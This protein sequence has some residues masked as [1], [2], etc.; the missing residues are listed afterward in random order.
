MMS[1]TTG[2]HAGS[3]LN[4]FNPSIVFARFD[5]DRGHGHVLE[6]YLMFIPDMM[7]IRANRRFVSHSGT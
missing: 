6:Q 5:Y 7:M 3:F 2:V 1:E 4:I